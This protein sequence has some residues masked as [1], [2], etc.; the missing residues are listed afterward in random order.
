MLLYFKFFAV[1][2][3]LC[4]QGKVKVNRSLRSFLVVV[5]AGCLANYVPLHW[6][7][8]NKQETLFIIQQMNEL[9]TMNLS[10]LVKCSEGRV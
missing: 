2:Q 9:N 1:S 3:K 5:L 4:E 10:Q 8:T 6:H 7:L